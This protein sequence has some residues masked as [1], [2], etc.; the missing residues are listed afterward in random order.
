MNI[1]LLGGGLQGLSFGESLWRKDDYKVSVISNEYD[2]KHSLFYDKVYNS[3][4]IGFENT[5][6]RVMSEKHFDVIVPM[7]DKT[8]SNLSKHKEEIEKRYGTK[9][10]VADYRSLSIVE[11]KASFMNFCRENGFPHPQTAKLSSINL[12][13]VAADIGFPALIKPDYSVGARGITRVDSL[14]ELQQQYP[15]VSAKYGTCT[16]QEFID[17]PDYYYN[18][19]LYRDKAGDMSH[20]VI[21]KI[22]RMYPIKGGSSSC[23]YTI[24]NNE[25]LQI[26]RN[27]LDKLEW[28]G[29]ADFD[30]LQRLDTME[31]KIIEINPRVPA[32]LRAAYVS[33]VNF[34]EI[35]VCD[36][37]GTQ[38]E[39]QKYSPGMTLRYMGIDLM[40]FAKS[41]KRFRKIFSWL[42]FYGRKVYYQ[43]IIWSDPSTWYSWF[44]VGI[45]KLG[46]RNM[47]IRTVQEP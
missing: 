4:T 31:Y 33:G 39:E 22:V 5:I 44:I 35:I 25:L 43:D 14:E 17:N 15:S 7:G 1:L 32:S 40:W 46:R 30:V 16:L 19:M 8:A 13:S 3:S 10:A 37:L 41:P 24:E 12:E 29:M 28:V 27:V 9:C 42:H 6:D 21:T 38:P 34:P 26:C 11:D 20:Y 36:A 18:V 23:C 45:K 47:V 2:I